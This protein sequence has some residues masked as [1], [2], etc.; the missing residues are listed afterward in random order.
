MTKQKTYCL[1]NKTIYA[2]IFF[3]QKRFSDESLAFYKRLNEVENTINHGE[4]YSKT[5][6]TDALDS[7]WVN[8]SRYFNVT[9]DQ[10]SGKFVLTRKI[11]AITWR[12]NRMG[13]MILISNQDLKPL[14][15]L[16]Y[17]KKKRFD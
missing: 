14:T 17:Y 1:N 9:Y 10:S 8:C 12:I 6:I 3:D 13:K 15:I 4:Y 16:E 5:H 2:T 11:N 7:M